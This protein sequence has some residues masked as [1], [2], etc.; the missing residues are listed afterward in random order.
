MEIVLSPRKLW[1]RFFLLQNSGKK[2]PD[3][4][5][6]LPEA[7]KVVRKSVELFPLHISDYSSEENLVRVLLFHFTRRALNSS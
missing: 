3:L 2:L 1:I 5:F 6:I 4:G 7:G